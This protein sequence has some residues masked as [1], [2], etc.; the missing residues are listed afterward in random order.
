MKGLLTLFIIT[1]IL[2][3]CGNNDSTSYEEDNIVIDTNESEQILEFREINGLLKTEIDNPTLYLKRA[4]LFMKYN[5]LSSAV[6]DLNRAIKI[7][8][9]APEYYLLKAELLKNQD[10]LKESKEAL[11]KCMRVDNENILARM[12]L[13]WLA[14]ISKNHK[15]ALDYADA[16]LKRDV[17]NAEAYFLKGMIFQDKGDTTLAISSFITA[18]E[19]EKDYYDAYMHLGL[20]HINQPNVLAKE[21]LKNALRIKPNSLEALYAY[22]MYSQEH[23]D[24][25]EAIET[26]FNILEIDEYREPY[27]NL[28]YIHQEYLKVYDV[29]IE[30]Y[31]K[32][33]EVE[34]RYLEAYYN[35]GLCYEEIEDFQKAE[36]DL[37]YALKLN[38]QYTHAAIALERVLN[39]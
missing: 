14:L 25:N 22:A 18:T 30:H 11:D 2:C 17:Y 28:G 29:A 27:F 13:G 32:A 38:P 21:Y 16:V 1:I 23:E 3:S 33:I 39:R 24:Y 5:D 19:R 35:R 10:K 12:E 8:S 6:A 31:T 20:L 15:Q 9:T 26:Y 4:K 37:R 34:P 36:E 7:D